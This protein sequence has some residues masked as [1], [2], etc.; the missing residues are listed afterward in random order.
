MEA[1]FAIWYA[2]QTAQLSVKIQHRLSRVRVCA[3]RPMG[4]YLGATIASRCSGRRNFAQP[5]LAQ[6]RALV[7]R[8]SV[9]RAPANITPTLA[10]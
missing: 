8:Q 2:I 5:V 4:G 3:E 1:S 6:Y 9:E 10:A 7:L